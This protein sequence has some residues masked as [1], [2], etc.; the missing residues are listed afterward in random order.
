MTCNDSSYYFRWKRNEQYIAPGRKV[1]VEVQGGIGP[2]DWVVT[3]SDDFHMVQATTAG[4]A[5]EV[6][7]DLDVNCTCNDCEV[8]VTDS[9]GNEVT[10][11]IKCANQLVPYG[12]SGQGDNSHYEIGQGSGDTTDRY[13]MTGIMAITGDLSLPNKSGGAHYNMAVILNGK[14]YGW[15][16]NL[17]GALGQGATSY[18]YEPT[19]LDSNTDWDYVGIGYMN[20][21]A[22][23]NETDWYCTGY[24]AYGCLGL[25]DTTNRTTL[26]SSGASLSA[27]APDITTIGVGTDG[28]LYAAGWNEYD[29]LGTGTFRTPIE[30]NSFLQIGT[31][32]SWEKPFMGFHAAAAINVFG[33][34]YTWGTELHGHIGHQNTGYLGH[35]LQPTIISSPSKLWTKVALCGSS[36]MFL[37]SDGTLWGVGEKKYLGIGVASG[38]QLTL[39]QL[40]SGVSDIAACFY[41]SHFKLKNGLIY[42]TGANNQGQLG[43]DPSSVPWAYS[44][45]LSSVAAGWTGLA[46]LYNSSFGIRE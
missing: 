18:V 46:T 13:S 15:G 39:L 20:L 40:D 7:A 1:T 17:S 44:W 19:L 30:S 36:S 21:F 3:P 5:N 23:R 8:I 42:G 24:N 14:L 2:F 34:L 25:G 45:R 9:C 27:V 38:D 16:T 6:Y 41:G 22:R 29:C 35:I 11:Y 32:S 12:I 10:G 33:E 26:T 43:A 37:A 31:D 28:K 4:R